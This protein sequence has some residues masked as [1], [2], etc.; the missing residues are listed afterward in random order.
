MYK[1]GGGGDEQLRV[2]VTFH[3]ERICQRCTLVV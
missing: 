1:G 2:A 3:L